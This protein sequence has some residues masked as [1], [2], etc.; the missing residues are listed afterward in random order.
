MIDDDVYDSITRLFCGNL[1]RKITE[2]ELKAYLPGIVYIKWITDKET[3][4]FYGSSF[5][6]MKDPAAAAMAV[7]QDKSKF[8][9]RPLKIYYCPPRPGDQWP[10]KETQRGGKTGAAAAAAAS[11]SSS[12]NPPGREKTP[13]PEG[14]RKLYMGNLSYDIDDDTVVDFFKDCGTMIGLRWLTRKDTGEFRV[15]VFAVPSSPSLGFHCASLIII[16]M[17]LRGVFVLRRCRQGDAS[18]WSGVAWQV[19]C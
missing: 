14:C 4:E 15:C 17:W 5:I 2:E 13:K 6:E 9:G 16:G 1:S 7:M 3:G 12:G 11:S 18:G 8:M 19:R 10:P